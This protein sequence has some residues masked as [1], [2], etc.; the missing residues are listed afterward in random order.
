MKI[1]SDYQGR[2]VRLTDER[3]QH[4]LLHPELV[5]MEPAIEETLKDPQLVIRSRSDGSA[6]LS[7]RLYRRTR[8][9]D[10]WLCV[11]VKYLN[12][13]AFVLTAYL[14]DKPKAGEQ[15]WPRA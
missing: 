1:L 15:L 2:P 4:I 10:K 5:G 11:V 3:R 13:E 8:V 9:G 14:T 12:A 7:Y 6:A